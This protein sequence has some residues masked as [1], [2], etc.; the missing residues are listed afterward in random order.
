MKEAINLISYY[1]NA[2]VKEAK[3]TPCEDYRSKYDV[4]YDDG[5]EEITADFAVANIKI[6]H[7]TYCYTQGFTIHVNINKNYFAIKR[8]DGKEKYYASYADFR[9]ALNHIFFKTFDK[10]EE[11]YTMALDDFHTE[12]A[13]A[14]SEVCHG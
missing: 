13:L 8:Y 3:L 4:K 5:R 14:V 11:D 12:D 10:F 9:E 1:A 7:K 6:K 2:F